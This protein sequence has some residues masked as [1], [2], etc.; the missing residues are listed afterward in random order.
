LTF[1][2]WSLGHKCGR[3]RKQNADG[4]DAPRQTIFHL[5]QQEGNTMTHTP[6]IVGA[7]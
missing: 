7:G 1:N 4:D 2:R 5:S 3:P 6:A